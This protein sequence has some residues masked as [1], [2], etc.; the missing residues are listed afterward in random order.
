[1]GAMFQAAGNAMSF[2]FATASDSA[3]PA[4]APPQEREFAVATVNVAGEDI[5]GL[6]V[7][8]TRGAKASGEI[9]FAGGVAPEGVSTIRLMAGST[10]PDGMGPAMA[11]F[12]GSSVKDDGTFT[13]DSLAGSR[14]FRVIGG[15]KGWILKRITVNG[16]DFTDKGIEFKPGED[17]SDITIELT[18]KTTSLAGSVAT[19]AASRSRTIRSSSLPRTRRSGRC[20]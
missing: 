18:N 9:T 12:G 3:A 15:P 19:I 4:A 6:V 13:M 17:V 2:A 7:V 1:M 20:Q 11:G 5:T 10:D 14:M 16:E 8:G